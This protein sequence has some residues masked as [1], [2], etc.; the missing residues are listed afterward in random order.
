MWVGE[1]F[2]GDKDGEG[3]REG[4]PMEKAGKIVDGGSVVEECPVDPGAHKSKIRL[5]YR[6]GLHSGY[7]ISVHFA[8]ITTCRTHLLVSTA[9]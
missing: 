5:P 7:L 9:F 8:S 1:L 2:C 3:Q 6:E 4:G